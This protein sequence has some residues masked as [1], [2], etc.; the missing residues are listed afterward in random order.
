MKKIKESIHF[1]NDYNKHSL[2]HPIFY[3]LLSRAYG[4]QGDLLKAHTTQAEYYYLNGQYK[5]A[6]MQIKIAKKYANNDFYSLS[7][8]DSKLLEIEQ[9]KNKYQLEPE[10]SVS[11]KKKKSWICNRV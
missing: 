3:Q 2:K 5:Q 1:I 7:K 8:L 9:E 6:M 11:R 10:K 4:K